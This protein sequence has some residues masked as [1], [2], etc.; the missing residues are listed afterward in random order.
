MQTNLS[1]L[2]VIGFFYYLS[3][4]TMDDRYITTGGEGSVTF[5]ASTS[6]IPEKKSLLMGHP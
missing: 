3:F 1:L 5:T 4:P 2:P 6:T